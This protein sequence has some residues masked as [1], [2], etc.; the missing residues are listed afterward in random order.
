[1]P[2]FVYL[3]QSGETNRYKIGI[4]KNI[5]QRFKKLG[6]T[7]A[8]YYV[9]PIHHIEVTNSRVIEKYLHRKYKSYKAKHEWF[10]LNENLV[11]NVVRDMVFEQILQLAEELSYKGI[12]E[13]QL[14][15]AEL[16]LEKITE[17]SER[18]C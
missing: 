4:T 7:D 6:G 5:D 13:L 10:E 14:K 18:P 11:K 12:L 16:C 2:E 15:I 8:P 3:V 9:Q 17:K 1:M